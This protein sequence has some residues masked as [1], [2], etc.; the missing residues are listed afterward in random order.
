MRRRAWILLLGLGLLNH[1]TVLCAADGTTPDGAP[2]AMVGIVFLFLMAMVVF[3][4]IFVLRMSRWTR[5]T[6][7]RNLT[8]QEQHRRIAEEHMKRLESQ[9]GR[10]DEKLGRLV[11]LLEAVDRERK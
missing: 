3:L 11:A 1:A 5:A 8:G 7:L 9:I 4:A 10:L 6:A 2:S